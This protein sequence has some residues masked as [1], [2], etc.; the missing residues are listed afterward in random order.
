M[1]TLD[2]LHLV[3]ETGETPNDPSFV[4]DTQARATEPARALA[5]TT[6]ERQGVE[7]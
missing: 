4:V 7:L 5:A 6:A 2:M 3:S 1:G